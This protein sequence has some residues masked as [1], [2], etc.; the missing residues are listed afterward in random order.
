MGGSLMLVLIT[1]LLELLL[2][3]P[4]QLAV[5]SVLVSLSSPVSITLGEIVGARD[6]S[7]PCDWGGVGLEKKV[8]MSRA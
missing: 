8:P 5:L 3:L 1:F 6:T 2:S 7:G 4:R